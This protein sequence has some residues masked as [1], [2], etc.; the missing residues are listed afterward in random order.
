MNACIFL[1]LRSCLQHGSSYST[2]RRTG[3]QMWHV[4]KGTRAEAL[5]LPTGPNTDS[6]NLG[7]YICKMGFTTEAYNP[8]F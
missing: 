4:D 2:G 6:L 1:I 8:S 5:T 3:K 7:S